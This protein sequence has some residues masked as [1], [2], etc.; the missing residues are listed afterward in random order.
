MIFEKERKKYKWELKSGRPHCEH[1]TKW[2]TADDL[3]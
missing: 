2:S 3:M 1:A